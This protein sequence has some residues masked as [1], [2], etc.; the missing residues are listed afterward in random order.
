MGGQ[1]YQGIR[2]VFTI[3]TNAEIGASFR[4]K[5]TICICEMSKS[6]S[7]GSCYAGRLKNGVGSTRG[8]RLL[9]IL[10]LTDRHRHISSTVYHTQHNFSYKVD[11]HFGKCIKHASDTWTLPLPS[12]I[13]F[14]C[15]WYTFNHP[16]ILTKRMQ[17]Y[18]YLLGATN[19]LHGAGRLRRTFLGTLHGAR[20]QGAT[21]P[22]ELR[23][24]CQNQPWQAERPG[25]KL[26]A[27][28]IRCVR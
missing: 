10:F 2:K 4:Y 25:H 14:W 20:S 3:H 11:P 23:L 17:T 7:H 8:R 12:L 22:V 6:H 24:S 18:Q 9:S 15:V 1:S 19:V 5:H 21:A 28:W 26:Q 27:L 13:T 16:V